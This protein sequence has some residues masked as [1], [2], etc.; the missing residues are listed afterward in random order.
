MGSGPRE[1]H[2]PPLGS[3]RKKAGNNQPPRSPE[4]VFKGIHAKL[5]SEACPLVHPSSIEE[6][7]EEGAEGL[8]TNPG[9]GDSDSE[10]SVPTPG[11][12]SSS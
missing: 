3:I 7:Q 6:D 12:I 4:K 11:M 2:P 5:K 9:Q 10:A 8:T 1:R